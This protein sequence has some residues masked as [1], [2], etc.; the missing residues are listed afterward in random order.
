MHHYFFQS[1]TFLDHFSS[2]PLVTGYNAISQP[3]PS[4]Y[5]TSGNVHLLIY[6]Q[7]EIYLEH[8]TGKYNTI[9]KLTE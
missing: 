9:K 3:L 7:V 8:I 4:G 1:K 6:L 5:Y 2:F